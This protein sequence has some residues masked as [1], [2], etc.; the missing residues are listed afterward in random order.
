VGLV[1]A[2]I[3]GIRLSSDVEGLTANKVFG[4]KVL[5]DPL[6]HKS[7]GYEA[8]QVKHRRRGKR[9]GQ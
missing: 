2:L 7:L 6:R 3:G 1:S 5:L 9:G 8:L 4:T